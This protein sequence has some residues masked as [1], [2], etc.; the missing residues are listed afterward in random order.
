MRP[1]IFWDVTQRWMV[2]SYWRLG[3][4][5]LTNIQG[6]RRPLK[7]GPIG[8][9]ETSA[10]TIQRCVASQKSKDLND[11]TYF[12]SSWKAPDFFSDFTPIWIFETYFHRSLRYQSSR[13]SIQW[14]DGQ[15]DI[16]KL[17][18]APFVN[19]RTHLKLEY[20]LLKACYERN[21]M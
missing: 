7:V 5:Y 17:I 1:S 14:T 19:M 3:T 21:Y 8:C 13:K 15:T 12:R 18:S 2:I 9:P 11:K 16:T 6:S 4:T 10:T 20:A